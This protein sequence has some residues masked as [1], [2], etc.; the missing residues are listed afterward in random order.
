MSHRRM[1]GMMEVIWARVILSGR[2]VDYDRGRRMMAPEIFLQ[3]KIDRQKERVLSW[4]SIQEW[5]ILERTIE[6]TE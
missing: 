2:C 1:R 4:S 5:V 3:N 6:Q